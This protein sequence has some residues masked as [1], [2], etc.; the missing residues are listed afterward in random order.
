MALYEWELSR[1]Q[2]DFVKAPHR[3][4]CYS[5]SFRGGK[6]IALC[7]K[8]IMRASNPKATEGL[9]RKTFKSL[10]G[11]TLDLLLHGTGDLPPMLPP[12]SYDYNQSEFRIQLKG[13]GRIL[14][15]GLDD[16]D[17]IRGYT[18]TGLAVD[19]A[20]DL[21]EHDWTIADSR[22]STRIEGLGLQTYLACNPATPEHWICKL[23][24]LGQWTPKLGAK[25]RKL[26]DG[27]EYWGQ[28]TAAHENPF[29]HA[30][31]L[32][33]LSRLTGTSRKRYYE[34]LWVGQE[35]LVYEDWSPS[36]HIRK[37]SAGWTRSIVSVD[38]GSRDPLVALLLRKHP[39]GIHV[40]QELYKANLRTN[41]KC[42]AIGKIAKSAESIIYDDSARQLGVDLRDFGLPA[43]KANKGRITDG[44]ARVQQVIADGSLTVDP[45]CINLIREI[46]SYEWKPGKDEPVEGN[47]HALDALRYGVSYLAGGSKFVEG[48]ISS[49]DPKPPEEKEESPQLPK[50]V[51]E[52]YKRIQADPF[53]YFQ[54]QKATN[55]RLP[56][57]VY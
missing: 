42:E 18:F 15:F 20:T 55:R 28:L 30:D 40:E 14:V 51:E 11:S 16:P 26:P 10:R 13:G 24:E 47:D 52:H 49:N 7:R 4:L 31:V 43:R 35:G 32:R 56:R 53:R 17:A 57:K 8:L 45:S 19:E 3:Y 54:E 41:Q 37:L 2:A 27:A 21:T 12:G 33:D 6:S 9:C 5:G 34:G 29:L 22:V 25:L 36:K 46:Q 23:F 44:I 39:S 1:K 38:D 48:W 50:E